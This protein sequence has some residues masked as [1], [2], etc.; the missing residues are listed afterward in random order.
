MGCKKY[1]HRKK[2]LKIIYA[3]WKG[4]G[5]NMNPYEVLGVDENADDA[6]IKKAY[7]ELVKKY[8]PTAT[9][10]IRLRACKGKLQRFNE[11]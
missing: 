9:R 1:P 8:H 5:M 7:R 10:T 6:T 3:P 11:A 2:Q 4:I